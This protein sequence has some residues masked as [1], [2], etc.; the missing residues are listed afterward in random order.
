MFRQIV[1]KQ[2]KV[3]FYSGVLIRYSLNI[4]RP[5]TYQKTYRISCC[6]IWKVAV[7]EVTMTE[8]NFSSV[9]LCAFSVALCAIA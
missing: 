8:S 3:V 7:S 6:Y 4:N 5:L 2:M 1:D 9:K